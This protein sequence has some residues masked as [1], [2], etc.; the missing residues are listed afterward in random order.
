MKSRLTRVEHAQKGSSSQ[1]LEVPLDLPIRLVA[2]EG[3][4][5]L[6][7]DNSEGLD[8]FQTVLLIMC[9]DRVGLDVL[10]LVAEFVLLLHPGCDGC[11]GR[12]VTI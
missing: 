2:L 4:F 10:G 6:H 11:E 1:A 8:L 7:I 9:I 12:R 3:G 5:V